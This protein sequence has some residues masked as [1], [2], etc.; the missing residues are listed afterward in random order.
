MSRPK[1]LNPDAPFQ[2]PRNT[3]NLTGLSLKF[4]LNGC[5][6]GTIPHIRVGTDYRVN[7]PLL[8]EK[9]NRESVGG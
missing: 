2:S 1:T 3:A 4:I 7:V 9:L 8:L 6:T 5:K